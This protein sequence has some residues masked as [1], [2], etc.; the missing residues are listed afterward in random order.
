MDLKP[1]HLNHKYLKGHFSI[2]S[3]RSYVFYQKPSSYSL[4]HHFI[5]F[6]GLY[7]LS[8]ISTWDILKT[9][10]WNNAQYAFSHQKVCYFMCGPIWA[11]PYLVGLFWYA[12]SCLRMYLLG[13][14]ILARPIG[15]LH[16]QTP[17]LH[18]LTPPTPAEF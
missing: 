2:S 8:Y 1:R 14:D 18:H 10:R 4:S 6:R 12:L 17:V 3:F 15:V 11:S 13:L 9:S 5:R 16:L 7:M